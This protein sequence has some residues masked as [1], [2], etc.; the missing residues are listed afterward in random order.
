MPPPGGMAGMGVSFSGFS[1]TI[2]SV[3]IRASSQ[4][5]L[6]RGADNLGRIDDAFGNQIAVLSVL[7]VVAIDVGFIS[8]DL[9]DDDRAVLASI[10]G[11]FADMLAAFRR[12]HLRAAR[13]RSGARGS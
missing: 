1:A 5:R 13:C 6:Q 4:S 11:D 2:A 9:A 10:D 7:C 3:V 8:T 12:K